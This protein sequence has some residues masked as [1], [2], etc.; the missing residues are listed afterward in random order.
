M[1]TPV[2]NCRLNSSDPDRLNSD[3]YGS[4][5]QPTTR[6][7]LGSVCPSPWEGALR[8]SGWFTVLTSVAVRVRKFSCTVSIR[9]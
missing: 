1:F 4:E 6:S 7:P 5:P 8:F 3:T 9:L 2:G